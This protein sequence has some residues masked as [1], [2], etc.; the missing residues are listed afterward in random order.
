M[1]ANERV[2]MDVLEKPKYIISSRDETVNTMSR[3]ELKYFILLKKR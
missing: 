2:N 3:E 1:Q